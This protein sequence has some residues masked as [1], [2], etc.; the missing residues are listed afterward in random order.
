[1]DNVIPPLAPPSMNLPSADKG[2]NGQITLK[3]DL[4]LSLKTGDSLLLRIMM[5]NDTF[6]ASLNTGGKSLTLEMK[7]DL[8]LQLVNGRQYEVSAR[9]TGNNGEKLQIQMLTID[10]RKA[11]TFLASSSQ[12]NAAASQSAAVVKELNNAQAQ[13]KLFPLKLSPLVENM[14][15]SINL[16]RGIKQHIMNAVG[17]IEL[18]V[19]FK[20]ILPAPL[21][22]N[23]PLDKVLSQMEQTLQNVSQY[24]NKPEVLTALLNKLTTQIEGLKDMPLAATYSLKGDANVPM[25][26]TALGKVL[27]ETTVKLKTDTNVML[28]IK[29]IISSAIKP[30]PLSELKSQ[31]LLEVISKFVDTVKLQKLFNQFEHLSPLQFAKAT[32]ELGSHSTLASVLKIIEPL[33]NSPQHLEIASKILERFPG[34]NDKMLSNSLSFVKAAQSHHPISWLGE[35]LTNELRGL[36]VEGKEVLNR[37]S[38]FVIAT[39]KETPVW[40]M[41]EM[42]FFNGDNMS[43]IRIALKKNE[44]DEENEKKRSSYKFGT[45]FVVETNFTRLGNFQFDGFSLAQDRRF[46]LIIRTS[47]E[48]SKDLCA[49][50]MTLFKTSLHEV[51]YVG[52]ININVKDNFIK[53]YEEEAIPSNLRKGVYI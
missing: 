7:P 1:M 51:N 18:K 5:E 16:S 47:N 9:V 44:D 26:D 28:Q 33:K 43:K 36:G 30:L 23:P 31:P 19:D 14:L 38:N 4:Q 17:N 2:V 48:I 20:S 22:H 29:E 46:D 3:P 35:E 49:N 39:N 37:I 25:M 32:P 11:E 15:E 6:K 10:S 52:N 12:K 50:I 21:N 24:Q 53:I 42:P 27:L 34:L 41:V 8:P 45:R 13:V 40:R